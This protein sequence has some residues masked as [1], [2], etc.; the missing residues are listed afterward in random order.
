MVGPMSGRYEPVMSAH[1][2]NRPPAGIVAGVIAFFALGL[3]ALFVVVLG[4]GHFLDDYCIMV[5][6]MVPGGSVEGSSVQGPDFGGP[7]HVECWNEH[8]SVRRYEPRPFYFASGVFGGLLLFSTLVG[9]AVSLEG[10]GRRRS[11]GSP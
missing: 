4:I 7:F 9:M 5:D 3:P 10:N 2:E 11:R 6:G 8:G 1:G